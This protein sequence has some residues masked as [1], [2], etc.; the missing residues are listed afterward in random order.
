MAFGDFTVTRASTKNVL[1]SAGLYVS[2]A[3]NVPA[4][5]FN[6]NGSYRGLLVEPGATNLANHSQ[7]FDNAYWGKVAVTIT[8]NATTAPD[9]TATA[10]KIIATATTG[11]HFINIAASAQTGQHTFSVFAKASEYTFIRLSDA[12][13]GK[14]NAVFDLSTGTTSSTGASIVSLPNGFY[15]CIVTYDGAGAN[16]SNSIIGIP[17]SATTINYTGNG[18]DGIFIWQAQLETGSVA[19]SPIV[20]TAGTASRVA[21]VVSLTGAS[22]LIGQTEGTLFVEAQPNGLLGA[23]ARTILEVGDGT[24]NNTYFIAFTGLASNTLRGG[25]IETGGADVDFRQVIANTNIFKTAIGVRSTDSA[26]YF[27]GA[28]TTELSDTAYSFP[29]TLANVYLGSNTSGANQFNGWI[30]SVAL[31]PT[32][33]SNAQLVTLTT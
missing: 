28:T 14:F 13:A 23:V 4:F 5:E 21:D 30:R 8:A 2:V 1:G 27:N 11:N 19:T 24:A 3:N 16:V 9:G 10:D 18:T 22:S 12:N 31:F 32:R 33:L 25:L 20:T 29:S 15:R 7:S 26:M 6:T 17:T